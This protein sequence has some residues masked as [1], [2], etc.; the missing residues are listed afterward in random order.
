[1]AGLGAE[2]DPKDMYAAIEHIGAVATESGT[3]SFADDLTV[4]NLVVRKTAKMPV[5]TDKYL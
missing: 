5:G 3:L 4:N 1:M 2:A